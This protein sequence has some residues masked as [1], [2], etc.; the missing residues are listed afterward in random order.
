MEKKERRPRADA[1]FLHG[2]QV[3]NKK[4]EIRTKK[5]KKCLHFYYLSYII[6]FALSVRDTPDK[7]H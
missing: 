5:V 7:R 2:K 4:W 1:P 6:A 3:K